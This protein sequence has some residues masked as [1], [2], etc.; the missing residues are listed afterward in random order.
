MHGASYLNLCQGGRLHLNDKF[1]GH[2]THLTVPAKGSMPDRIKQRQYNKIHMPE[3]KHYE[4]MLANCAAN[5][6]K[7]RVSGQVVFDLVD[8]DVD[9]LTRQSLTILVSVAAVVFCLFVILTV[10][11]NMGTRSDFEQ[12][13]YGLVPD[14]D[15]DEQPAAAED[16]AT[17]NEEDRF[18]DEGIRE[19]RELSGLSRMTQATIV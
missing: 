11:V 17:Q 10:R 18:E 14:D 5:G 15:E 4:V 16:A 19:P 3:A 2:A 6:R 13:H 7:V 12:A 9:S 8:D 1:T